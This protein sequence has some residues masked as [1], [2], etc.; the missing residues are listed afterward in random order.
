MDVSAGFRSLVVSD[1]EAASGFPVLVMYP[2]DAAEQDVAL[3]PYSASLAPNATVLDGR[4]P[5][6]VV[7]HGTGGS[8]FVYRSLAAHLAR[9]GFVVALPEHPQNNRNDDTLAGTSAILA[10]RPAHVRAVTDWMFASESFQPVLKAGEVALIGHSLGGY[11]ALALAGGRATAFPH[12][13]PDGLAQPVEVLPDDRVKALVL[14]APATPWFMADGALADVRVPILMF[15]A[16]LDEHTPP[17][18]GEIV[19]R[20]V[21]GPALVEHRVV[22]N[23][24]HFSFLTPFPEHMIDPGFPPS[25]D[26]EGF[27]RARFHG[28]LNRAV[29]AFLD[30][31]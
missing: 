30:G 15:S 19:L 22:A 12:E 21:L 17:W 29:T 18:Q 28:E 9:H 24:G 23:A 14:L 5:L 10:N 11:T 8:P 27:D 6:V 7:S 31:A 26:P 3:G 25:Q 13:T 2:T 20:G 16:E 1:G 4:F